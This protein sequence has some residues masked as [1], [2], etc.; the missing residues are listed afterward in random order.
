MDTIIEILI[1]KSGSM[2]VFKGD[3][4]NENKYL[5]ED[6]STRTDLIKKMMIHEIIPTIDYAKKI[7]I[8]TFRT[9]GEKYDQLEVKEIYSGGFDGNDII[10]TI[11][12]LENPPLGG[13]PI[14]AALEE[15]IN[16]LAKSDYR[17]HDRKIILLT[18]GEEN[19]KGN[20]LET[21]QKAI[22]LHGIPCKIFI[23]G[24]SQD[25]SARMKSK[26]LAEITNGNY[27]NV[28]SLNYNKE[29]IKSVLSPLKTQVIKSSLE[30]LTTPTDVKATQSNQVTSPPRNTDISKEP[31][32]Q[33]E[34]I[35]IETPTIHKESIQ[36]NKTEEIST[37]I[38][39]PEI[40]PR[41]NRELKE[42]V[43]KNSKALN[44]ITKQLDNLSQEIS[45]LKG[46][47]NNYEEQ[48][49]IVI[50]ENREVNEQVRDASERFLNERLKSKYSDRLKWLN[51]NGES[52]ADH[53]F[54]VL[55][56]DNSVEYF[57]ECKGS[58][59]NEKFFYL[60]KNEW[61]LFIQNT[62]NYQIYFVSD[63]LT[64]PEMTKIDNLLDWI[65]KGKIYPM[66]FKNR[67]VKAERI[68]MTIIGK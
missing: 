20:Y 48:E 19:G 14:S 47:F 40:F 60:T 52:G 6:G 62:K 57:I 17:N 1:D 27:F 43:E 61:S 39:Q 25:D 21:A 8:R 41:E 30:N 38:N 46:N 65:L 24:I 68:M 7:T 23:V 28:S 26:Q 10:D 16:E 2:G 9:V 50:T 13:T 55:D 44:L 35:K 49:E 36:D 4:N 33:S 15:S 11:N 3:E 18:D 63:A 64:S 53:D 29:Y 58:K 45:S 34:S 32:K 5:L 22:D 42:V 51:E 12:S 31:E 66:S 59:G 56:E 37:I 54:E 67:K